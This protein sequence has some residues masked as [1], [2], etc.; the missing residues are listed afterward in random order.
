M[1]TVHKGPTQVHIAGWLLEQVIKWHSSAQESCD[2][3]YCHRQEILL[4]LLSRTGSLLWKMGD[5]KQ[6][7]RTKRTWCIEKANVGELEFDLKLSSFA[8]ILHKG[9]IDPLD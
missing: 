9:N 4:R 8:F 1:E 6:K 2:S 5:I 7:S 3:A